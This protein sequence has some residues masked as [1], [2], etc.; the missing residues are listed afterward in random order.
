MRPA[1]AEREAAVGRGVAD[2]GDQQRDQVRGLGA[3][4]AVQQHEQQEVRGGGGDPD[5]REPHRLAAEAIRAA[6]PPRDEPSCAASVCTGMEPLAKPRSSRAMPLRSAVAVATMSTRLSGSSTQSTGTSWM[7]SPVRSANTSSSVSKNQPVSAMCGSRRWATSARTALKPHCASENPRG[8]SG[9]QDQVVAARDDLALGAAHHAGA[10]AQ[11]GADG[12]V[13]VAGDQRRDK[14][15]ERRQIGR[16]VDVHVREH[17]GVGRR[18]HRVQCAA[19]ALLL[20]PHHPDIG[21]LCGEGFRDSGRV[22]D[23]GVVCD[24]DARRERE[25]VPQMAVQPVHRIGQRGLLVVHRDHHIEH[26]HACGTGR[27]RRV[28]PRFE[29]GSASGTG[30]SLEGDIGHDTNG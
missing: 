2:R 30:V 21:E 22:I 3:E 23:A 7:R 13:G 26:G 25:L 11:P 5:A 9:F 19:A 16:Q 18:P 12:K 8:Q 28:R 15:G 14:G 10:A 4:P 27:D 17:R 6:R 29:T 24:R 20:E 1:D